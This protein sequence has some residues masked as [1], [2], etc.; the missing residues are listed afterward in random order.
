MNFWPGFYSLQGAWF[1]LLL[2][3]LIVFYFLKLKRPHQ[4]VPSLALWN[5]V[6]NDRRVNS[7]FQKF[8]RSILLLLQ[9]LLLLFLV[10]ALMQPYIQSG[11]ERAEYLPI[12]ID[13]SASMAATDPQTKKTR[14]ELAKERVGEL[15]ENML[16]DQ[17]ISLV[18]V[19]STARRL[20]DFTDNQRVLKK[21]LA[22]LEVDDV[23]SQLEDALRMTQALSRTAPIKS[24]LFYSDGN[25]PKEIDFELPF[26]LNYQ[27]LPP[28]GANL[29]I[30]SMNARVNQ[31]GNWD[32]FLRIENSKQGDSPAVVEL[33]QDG[34][35][36]AREDILLGP[37]DSQRL[38]FA[39]NAEGT[40]RLKAVLTPGATDSLSADNEAFLTLPQSRDLLVYVDPELSSYRYALDD[41]K[42]LLLYPQPDQ[43]SLPPEFDLVISGAEKDMDRESLVKLGV[44]FVPEE[45]QKY[46]KLE[47]EL[48]NVVDWNRSS[49]LLRHVELSDVQI[50]QQPVW[51]KNSGVENLEELGYEVLIH[52]KLGPLL[53]QKR[54]SADQEFYF[55]F[56]TDRSTLP[57]RVGF[58]IMVSNLVQL[59]LQEAGIAETQAAATPILPAIEF[60]PEQEYQITTPEGKRLTAESDANGVLS[61][62]AALH[63]GTYQINGAGA[64]DSEISVSLLNPLETSLVS[65]EE[66]QF[67]EVPVSAS[68]SQIDSDKPLWSEFALIAFFL[69]LLEWWYFQRKPSG[70]PT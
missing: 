15:I 8:K 30:T 33:F 56:N 22:T 2:I 35:S 65:V 28:A 59:T 21:S 36:V 31:A 44:G 40:S 37:G 13:C 20:T 38:E 49:T 67:S 5:Q 16:P 29:G 60:Q 6:I 10:L 54:N 63:V 48:T 4:R 62:V 43:D 69:L 3:P 57:Y 52:G 68:Q 42:D 34:Q 70:I 55:L 1:L 53:L 39:I 19:G 11:A 27:L 12:L 50:T 14:L 9:I 51:T 17:R 64:K 58:P 26:E 45:L 61:G 41:S 66:M 32:V 46:I 7:P 25:F 23:P 24:V 18:A 47:P